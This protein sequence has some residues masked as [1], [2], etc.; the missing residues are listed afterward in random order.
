[1]TNFPNHPEIDRCLR[2]G[3]P[4]P[5]AKHECRIC[6]APAECYGRDSGYKC[7]SCA[8]EEFD[9]LRDAEAVELLGFEVLDE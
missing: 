6:G 3:H 7:F 8:R 1:M 5:P 2:T 4:H 9:D